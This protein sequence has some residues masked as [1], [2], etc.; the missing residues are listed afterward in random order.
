MHGFNRA[1]SVF[2]HPFGLTQRREGVRHS[3]KSVCGDG[4]PLGNS[5]DLE[6]STEE[7]K[8]GEWIAEVSI[9]AGNVSK[10]AALSQRII[11][12][13]RHWKRSVR[14]IKCGLKVPTDRVI[15]CDLQ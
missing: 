13:L 1:P 9:N 11:A 4:R 5:V 12:F 10:R 6:R 8:R 7:F 14:I 15:E 2:E 3:G